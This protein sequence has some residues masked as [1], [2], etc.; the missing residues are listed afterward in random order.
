M[1]RKRRLGAIAV[2]AALV[3]A[4]C[5]GDD[6]DSSDDSG[7]D[8]TEDTAADDSG[9]DATEDTAADDSGDD[10]TE[11]TAADDSGDD[12]APA[13]R[14]GTV[15]FAMGVPPPSFQQPQVQFG[16]NNLWGQLIFDPLLRIETDGTTILPGIATDWEYNEDGTVLTL[17]LR[18]DVMFTDGTPV[19]AEAAAQNLIR[20]RDGGGPDANDVA[21]IANATAV[22]ATTLEIELSAPNPA[23]LAILARNAGLLQAPSSFDAPDADQN[24]VGSGPYILDV[25]ATEP[26]VEYVY[27]PNEDYWDPSIQYWDEVVMRI[28]PDSAAIT[29]AFLAGEVNAGNPFTTDS[30]G[31][32][33]GAGLDVHL[34][35]L[36]WVGFSMIDRCGELGSPLDNLQVRQAINHAVDGEAVLDV[37]GNGFG[38]PTGQTFPVG[39][40]GYDEAL[41]D[42]YP[43]DPERAKELMAESGVGDFTLTMPAAYAFFGDAVYAVLADY[44]GEIGITVEYEEPPPGD[45]ITDLLTPKYPAYFMF[46]GQQPVDWLQIQRLIAPNAVWNPGGCTD[47]TVEQLVNDIQFATDPD[48]RDALTAELGAHVVEEAWYAPMYRNENVYITDDTVDVTV[49]KGNAIPYLWNIVPEG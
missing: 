19:D 10:A 20:F 22:D 29:N 6:D 14:A 2:T 38:T 26:D 1:I 3:L 9:D 48:E 28:I 32:L 42:V 36:D 45:F 13:E 40:A 41:D 33:E 8:A 47:D 49:Q 46:L 4:A 24:P 30:V 37:L 23:M 5:G 43:Y 27:T 11:D 31:Q 17:T 39:S 18:D 15:T 25:D 16:N 12:A 34:N 7:D 21:D 35:E 44:L